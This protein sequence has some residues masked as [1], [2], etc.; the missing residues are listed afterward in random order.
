MTRL[1]PSPAATVMDDPEDRPGRR[2]SAPSTY[3]TAGDASAKEEVKADG[4]FDLWLKRS[5]HQMYDT[6]ASEPIPDDLLRL[7]EDDRARRRD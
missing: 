3:E 2:G 6:I 7:I 1:V 5:L 4:A